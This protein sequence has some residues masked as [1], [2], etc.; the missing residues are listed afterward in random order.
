MK[1]TQTN[2]V[3]QTPRSN[4]VDEMPTMQYAIAVS[5]TLQQRRTRTLKH[6]DMF[7]V[8]DHRGDMGG[9]PGN[10][11]GLYYRDTR[12]LSQFQLSP[13]EGVPYKSPLTRF[14]S[15]LQPTPR[16]APV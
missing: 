7:A 10:S 6:G 5:D 16:P 15:K 1:R 4:T 9:E 13:R 3:D 11:E 12:M 14:G 8:F 2:E